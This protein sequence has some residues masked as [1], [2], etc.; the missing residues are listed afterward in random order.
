MGM[1]GIPKTALR[2]VESGHMNGQLVR[3]FRLYGAGKMPG[4]H[5]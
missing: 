1:A 2:V 4:N 5:R 3:V